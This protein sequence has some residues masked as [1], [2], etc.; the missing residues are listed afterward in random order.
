[1][2]TKKEAPAARAAGISASWQTWQDAT[3]RAVF[4]GG[5]RIHLPILAGALIERS[6]HGVS[7]RATDL[8]VTT[9]THMV[10]AQLEGGPLCINARLLLSALRGVRGTVSASAARCEKITVI[11]HA[12]GS[13]TVYGFGRE[14]KLGEDA[15]LPV[16]DF[17]AAPNV[18]TENLLATFA[19]GELPQAFH[20]ARTAAG[21]DDTLP[22]LTGVRLESDGERVI[23]AATNRYQLAVLELPMADLATFEA[24]VP[25][26]YEPLLKEM[27]GRVDV[28]GDRKEVD[29]RLVFNCEHVTVTTRLLD[30]T[31]PAYR[32][33]LPN[34]AE[35]QTWIAERQAL[36]GDVTAAMTVIDG[37]Q[38]V[39]VELAPGKVQVQG[40][41]IRVAT[42]GAKD[43]G[44]WTTAFNPQFLLDSLKAFSGPSIT[45][46]GTK[47]TKPM[48]LRGQLGTHLATIVMMPVRLP[49]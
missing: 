49:D 34:L 32:S 21:V 11:P 31:F 27:K 38:P 7:M 1:M 26:A 12:Y 24:L 35:C 43:E 45:L 9:E 13:A 28:F 39:R 40:S 47:A 10:D 25:G 5:R 15:I 41:Q 14:L 19:P 16:E 48:A 46:H 3:K 36:I 22:M 44:S 6:A 2:A 33:L 30:A 8:E 23:F 37:N 20:F 29:G 18:P 42:S 17:P 4:T